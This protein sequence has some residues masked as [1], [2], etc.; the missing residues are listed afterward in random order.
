MCLSEAAFPVLFH[1]V[2][3]LPLSEGGVLAVVV[4]DLHSLLP[5]SQRLLRI[6]LLGSLYVG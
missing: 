4:R 3:D 1:P 5:L 2:A 6:N